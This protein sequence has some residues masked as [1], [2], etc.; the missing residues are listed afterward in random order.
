MPLGTNA[1]LKDRLIKRTISKGSNTIKEIDG[2]QTN[3]TSIDPGN[4]TYN[5][6]KMTF[7]IKEEILEKLYNFA[8]W[9]RHSVTE[10]INLVLADGLKGKSTAGGKR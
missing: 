7:Y 10:A 2:S 1:V 4:D 6:K 5:T 9:D 8:Y 3:T